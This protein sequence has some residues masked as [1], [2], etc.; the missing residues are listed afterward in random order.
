MPIATVLASVAAICTIM[1]VTLYQVIP[2]EPDLYNLVYANSR[3][4]R[5]EGTRGFLFI[6]PAFLWLATILGPLGMYREIQRRGTFSAAKL[7]GFL[8]IFA[9]FAIVSVARYRVVVQY[10]GL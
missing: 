5:P 6:F 2:D 1:M 3:L 7:V 10:Y 9:V 4:Q 8:M